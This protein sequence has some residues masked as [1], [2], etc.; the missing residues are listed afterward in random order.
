M[1]REG[2][3]VLTKKRIR[4]AFCPGSGI[5]IGTCG[6]VVDTNCRYAKVEF[7]FGIVNCRYGE[8]RKRNNVDDF[9]SE[10]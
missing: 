9:L 1:Y 3:Q 7:D 6:T 10:W 4:T 2:Q 8:I 5:P